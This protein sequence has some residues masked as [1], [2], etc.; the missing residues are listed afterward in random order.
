MTAAAYR[1]AADR[2]RKIARDDY[3]SLGLEAHA[4]GAELCARV[5]DIKAETAPKL[6][7]METEL[8]AALRSAY[9]EVMNPGTT[10]RDGGDMGAAIL[11]VIAKATGGA[12]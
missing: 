2:C 7:P 6:T 3:R 12:A 8:L 1:D 5:L 11:A 4:T 9:V 10:A